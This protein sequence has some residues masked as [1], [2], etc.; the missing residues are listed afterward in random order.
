MDTTY[1]KSTIF[2]Y[3]HLSKICLISSLIFFCVTI[4]TNKLSFGT[5]G[6]IYSFNI[7]YYFGI[8]LLIIG[9]GF[10]LIPQKIPKGLAFFYLVMFL[11]YL[12]LVP[13]LVKMCPTRTSYTCYGFVDL[14][15]RTGFFDPTIAFYHNWPGFSIFFSAL[16]ML[17]KINTIDFVLG[18]TPFVSTLLCVIV[19]YH[20]FNYFF[21]NNT[22]FIF[23]A[24]VIFIFSNYVGQ[25]F[26]SP[27]GFAFLIYVISISLLFRLN[28]RK[29]TL[30][31]TKTVFLF[32]ILFGTLIISH[33]LTSLFCILSVIIF[34]IFSK[35]KLRK[36]STTLI[37]IILVGAWTIYGA[38]E[39]FQ[40]HIVSFLKEAFTFNLSFEQNVA[41]VG[42]GG[43]QIT[44][45]IV[46]LFTVLL[47]LF[48]I[49]GWFTTKKNYIKKIF[50]L[51]IL[52]PILL[53]IF[54]SY[55]GEMLARAVL[56]SLIPLSFFI[57]LAF[58]RKNEANSRYY[59]KIILFCIVLLIFTP[60]H[61]TSHYST[62]EYNYIA[63]S[64]KAQVSFFRHFEKNTYELISQND[65]LYR[66]NNIENFSI[67]LLSKSN[68]DTEMISG[69]WSKDQS[70][71][72]YAAITRSTIQYF[73]SFMGESEN[74]HLHEVI[75]FLDNST[76]YDLIY[77]SSDDGYLYKFK[78]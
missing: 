59:L 19:I 64:E 3:S 65:P 58:F 17:T 7:F 9:F 15:L 74:T 72:Q 46:I 28:I 53:P 63:P 27:Q 35:N 55:N 12:W 76:H 42:S 24:C 69:P 60:L 21:N 30:D 47:Y 48:A 32:F 41:H 44:D 62:D 13:F 18:L 23:S 68:L 11:V 66:Y 14:I 45:I 16:F 2:R 33:L 43:D 56:F 29:Y 26:F 75:D 34:E 5:L 54:Y 73:K 39:Y 10:S 71:P 78:V 20:F 70:L 50:T 40:A 22:R 4:L 36:Y 25:D 38:F 61:L 1:N 52:A 31:K 49:I 77:S 8:T 37:S 57:T 51:F 6:L 67:V